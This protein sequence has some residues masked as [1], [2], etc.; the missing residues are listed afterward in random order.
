MMNFYTKTHRGWS[1][2]TYDNECAFLLFQKEVSPR[3][4]REKSVQRKNLKKT[5]VPIL[6]LVQWEAL[7]KKHAQQSL[8]IH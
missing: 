7:L 2:Q 6:K 5:N 1:S 4:K 8:I 3:P